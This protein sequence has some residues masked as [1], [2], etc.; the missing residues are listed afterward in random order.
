MHARKSYAKVMRKGMDEKH[1][2]ISSYPK[3]KK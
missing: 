3:V 1:P 2:L